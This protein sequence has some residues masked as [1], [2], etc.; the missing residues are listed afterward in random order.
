MLLKKN[1]KDEA[2]IRQ[3][4]FIKAM[5]RLSVLLFFCDKVTNLVDVVKVADL[6]GFY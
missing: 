2:I 6:C 5:S 3:P 1:V 4:G